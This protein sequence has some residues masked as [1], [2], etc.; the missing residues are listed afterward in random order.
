[1]LLKI[2]VYKIEICFIIDIKRSCKWVNFSIKMNAIAASCPANQAIKQQQINAKI[3]NIRFSKFFMLLI[4][5]FCGLSGF[6]P[7]RV[8]LTPF[9][10]DGLQVPLLAALHFMGLFTEYTNHY[11][12]LCSAIYPGQSPPGQKIKMNK[13][14]NAHLPG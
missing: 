13:R 7:V 14:T 9:L 8:V 4:F 5:C 2:K 12:C 11:H 3:L 10:A 1:M 6:E